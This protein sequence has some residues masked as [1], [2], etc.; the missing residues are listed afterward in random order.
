MGYLFVETKWVPKR[1]IAIGVPL[2]RERE[3]PAGRF[4]LHRPLVPRE[5]H[6]ASSV[7]GMKTKMKTKIKMTKTKTLMKMKTKMKSKLKMKTTKMKMK[8]KTKTKR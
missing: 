4:T 3:T 5:P 6:R 1:W 7:W 8:M 2:Y